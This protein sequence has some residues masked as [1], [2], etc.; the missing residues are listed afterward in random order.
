MNLVIL[1]APRTP[2]YL[3]QTLASMHLAD[4]RAHEWKLHLLVDNA[5]DKSFI[6]GYLHSSRV[7]VLRTR[8]KDQGLPTGQ[9]IVTNF[10][11]M[12][13]EM[14]NDEPLV[15]IEDDIVFRDGWCDALDR[16]KKA[17]EESDTSYVLTGY[18]PY[19]FQGEERV[20][21]MS[22]FGEAF[23][24]A[25]F[26]FIPPTV[27]ESLAAYMVAHRDQAFGDILIQRWAQDE[28]V[29]I[30]AMVPS[31][32]QHMGHVSGANTPP[33]Q[34]KMFPRADTAW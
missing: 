10:A 20:A 18:A 32:A 24:G 1:T 14:P 5:P 11:R 23:Y 16:A 26:L 4:P 21:E 17:C 15:L 19:V 8:D 27:R 13:R 28:L 12:L 25:Q 2:L 9:R 22:P 34:T 31:V 29:P 6:E 30:F 7:H 33:H 3:H